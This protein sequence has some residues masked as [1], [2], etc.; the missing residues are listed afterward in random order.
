MATP[1]PERPNLDQLKNQAKDLKKAHKAGD[2]KA[3]ERIQANHPRLAGSSVHEIQTFRFTLSGAQLVIAREYGFTS[4]PKLKAHVE[5]LAPGAERLVEQF[6]QAIR[7]DDAAGAGAYS[8]PTPC[9]ERRS[10]S[11]WDLLTHR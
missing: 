2:P 4:W 5:S 9:C 8:R 10:T 6:T 3:L 7:S 1:L 11:R